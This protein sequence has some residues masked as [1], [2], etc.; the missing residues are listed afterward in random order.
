MDENRPTVKLKTF[1]RKKYLFF[2]TDDPLYSWAVFSAFYGMKVGKSNCKATDLHGKMTFRSRN[3]VVYSIKRKR[4][5]VNCKICFAKQQLVFES[6]C[7]IVKCAGT[8]GKVDDP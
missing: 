7:F 4:A 6:M 1:K 8:N 5:F 2:F 3:S